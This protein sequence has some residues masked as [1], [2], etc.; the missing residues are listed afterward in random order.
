MLCCLLMRVMSQ[1]PDV[2]NLSV[3]TVVK[4][5][6]L[7]FCVMGNLGFLIVMIYVCAL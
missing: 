3:R 4:L 7:G 6:A 2:C 1:S 5:C